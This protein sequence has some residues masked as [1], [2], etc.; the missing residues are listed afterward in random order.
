VLK[1][2]GSYLPSVIILLHYII[3]LYYCNIL[4][5][6]YCIILLVTLPSAFHVFRALR[7]RDILLTFIVSMLKINKTK[8]QTWEMGCGGTYL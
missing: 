1:V 2:A 7:D 8:I 5:L 6:Y 4:L 3:I